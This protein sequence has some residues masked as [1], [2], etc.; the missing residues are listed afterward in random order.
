MGSKDTRS[1]GKAISDDR[2]ARC[3]VPVR[4][5][6]GAP[7]KSGAAFNCYN[8]A[9]KNLPRRARC[10]IMIFHDPYPPR[11]ASYCTGV[12]TCDRNRHSRNGLASLPVSIFEPEPDGAARVSFEL[13][14]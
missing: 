2:A 10:S 6:I 1:S 5:I 4:M 14:L 13:I 7:A 8:R 12:Y 11:Y 9:N 3:A